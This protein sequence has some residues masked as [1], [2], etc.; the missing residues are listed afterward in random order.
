MSLAI[1]IKLKISILTEEKQQQP[2][3]IVGYCFQI[4]YNNSKLLKVIPRRGECHYIR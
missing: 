2:T 3:K 4:C 1:F